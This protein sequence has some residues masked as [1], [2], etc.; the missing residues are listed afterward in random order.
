MGVMYGLF[1][2]QLVCTIYLGGGLA[3]EHMQV[4]IAMVYYYKGACICSLTNPSQ[5]GIDAEDMHA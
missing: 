2:S 1:L 4:L 5:V 3:S